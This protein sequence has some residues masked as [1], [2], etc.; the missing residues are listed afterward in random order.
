[1]NK[2]NAVTDGSA[3]RG[4]DP[5]AVVG[6]ACRLPGAP[7]TDAFWKLLSEEND[8]VSEIPPERFDIDAWYDPVPGRPRRI[9]SRFGGFLDNID[10]FDADFFGISPYEAVRL[11]PQQRLMLQTTWEALEDAG[12]PQERA[13]KCRTGVYATSSSFT[14]DYWDRL[15]RAGMYD[16]HAVMGG[17]AWGIPAG[18]IS[19]QFDL[20]GP[21]MG[22]EATCGTSLLAVHFA[23]RGL[24]AGEIDMAIVAGAGLLLGPDMY[25]ALS[26]A[27]VLSPTGRCRFA[28]ARADGYV[29]SE[30]VIATVLK[31]LSRA[32][33][34]GDRVDAV[35]LG[36]AA[37]NDGQSGGT[38]TRPGLEGQETTL[39]AAYRDAGVPPGQVDYVEAHGSGTPT[40]DATELTA[41]GRVLGE[42]RADGGRC[43]VGS[44]KSNI[45]HTEITAGL[46]GL[47]K[48]VLALRH[49]T[50]P[51]TLHVDKPSPVFEGPDI[52]IEPALRCQPWPAR[53][54]PALAGVTSVALSGTNVHVVLSEAPRPP[55]TR[56][57]RRDRP[58]YLLPVSA[59]DEGALRALAGSYADVLAGEPDD[60]ALADVCF[61]AGARR[62]HH[63]HRLA[64]VG[65]DRRAVMEQLRSAHSGARK[66]SGTAGA[67]PPRVVFVFPGQG[68]QWVGM[69]RE[70]L[71]VSPVFARRLHAC[72]RAVEAELG[73]SP[74]DR[75]REGRPLS[76]VDEIQPTLWAMQVALAEVW[77]DWGIE[78]DLVL[79]HSMGEIA[80][81][82]VAGALTVRQA[83]SVVCRRSL[84]V[85]RLA[86]PGAMWAVS[87]G[88]RAAA[89]A[90]GEF[91]DQV[92]VGVVNSDHSTVLSGDSAALAKVVEPLRSRGVLCQQVRVDF[93]SHS[94]QVEPLRAELVRSLAR[95]RPRS[96][97]VPMWSTV[98]NEPVEGTG[99]DAEYWVENLRRP[100]RFAAAVRSILA[101]RRDTL[102]VEISPHPL[103]ASALEDGIHSSEAAAAV[104]PSLLRDGPELESMLAGL[105]IAYERGCEPNWRRLYEGGRFV[106]LPRYPW[107][108][109]R[110]WV[111]LPGEDVD[112]GPAPP[113]AVPDSRPA[114]G[115][116]SGPS[117]R[118]GPGRRSDPS[119]P[120]GP[121]SRPNGPPSRGQAHAATV[122]AR[123]DQVTKSVTTLTL[124]LRECAAETLATTCERIGPETPLA[125]VGLDSVLAAK[126][127]ARIMEDIN[128]R[129]P[130]GDLLSGRTLSDLAVELYDQVR[131]D[132]GTSDKRVAS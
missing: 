57:A 94:P 13:A 109:R 21:S 23:C 101:N 64:V 69:G 113:P 72:A 25:F 60:P 29:R 105:G 18:R 89:E 121:P 68:A 85:K 132:A 37:A 92:C 129:A 103:L 86:A 75:L 112:A 54:R 117:R 91:A 7:D 128:L 71:E 77:R 38:M 97:R 108:G 50:I 9:A 126:M 22:V 58:A 95:L 65:A 35:I 107:Q 119:R 87:L 40:G 1:V 100:V 83:A 4:R 104:V 52:P 116:R 12:I 39:R 51:A 96:A 80:A 114:T 111:D 28:D 27:E 73:W 127:R 81:A 42:G 70:L 55:V 15:R 88:E 56:R 32:L 6:M 84:L 11:A 31:P 74:V 63:Q 82:T 5:V 131:A 62:T 43:L 2:G 3:R 49:R 17:G 115:R 67:G 122:N 102:F 41:L 8:A 118:S 44:A 106:P 20:R 10:Q 90:I 61:S 30:G 125:V 123:S 78:P 16:L 110:F 47:L 59:R 46:T 24:W 34:D 14:P 45:G 124:Y 120:S 48:T 26:E 76:T 130:A 19:Y 99:L 36:S 53:G 66:V 98:T 93:A 33:E 79:G